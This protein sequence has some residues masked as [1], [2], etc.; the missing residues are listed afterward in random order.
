MTFEEFKK[1]YTGNEPP[2]CLSLEL[3]S[4]WYAANDDWKKAHELIQ[5]EPGVKCALIHAYLHRL[6]GDIG[7]A[8]YWYSKAGSVRPLVPEYEEFELLV[9]AFI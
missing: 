3:K 7:N 6:E 2:V 4:L 8:D 9:K 1:S 5:Y